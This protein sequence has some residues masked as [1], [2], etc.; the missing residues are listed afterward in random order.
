[1]IAN[2][3]IEQEERQKNSLQKLIFIVQK[4]THKI[5]FVGSHCDIPKVSQRYKKNSQKKLFITQ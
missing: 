3:T 5:S 2:F 1:M 4:K